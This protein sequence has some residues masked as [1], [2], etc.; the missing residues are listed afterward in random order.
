MKPRLKALCLMRKKGKN[1]QW[2]K[3]QNSCRKVTR[4]KKLSLKNQ[5]T[6]LRGSA[7]RAL[8]RPRRR[9][10]RRTNFLGLRS[11][12]LGVHYCP[13]LRNQLGN[14]TNDRTSHAS[15]L[16]APLVHLLRR[17][18]HY[19]RVPRRSRKMGRRRRLRHAQARRRSNPQKPR[20]LQRNPPGKA[21]QRAT[22]PSGSCC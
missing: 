14:P 12:Y 1:Q 10:G 13:S 15:R 18:P 17:T 9:G 22:P 21:P 6:L 16:R 3:Y 8:H 2:Q 20:I 19:R 7:S 11:W 5:R 4:T